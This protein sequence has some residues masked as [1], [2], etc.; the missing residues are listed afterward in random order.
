M[1]LSSFSTLGIIL[2][3]KFLDSNTKLT[4]EEHENLEGKITIKEVGGALKNMKNDKTP[5]SDG[6]SAELFKFFWKDLQVFIVS[7]Y[8][9][10]RVPVFYFLTLIFDFHLY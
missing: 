4:Q 7:F 6:Y 1:A 5:G 2:L 3:A 10:F 8:D 9:N